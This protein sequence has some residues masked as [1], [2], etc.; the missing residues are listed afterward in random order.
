MSRSF[1]LYLFG[2]LALTLAACQTAPEAPP[3]P[4]SPLIVQPEK[5]DQVEPAPAPIISAV[6]PSGY[7]ALPNMPS[8]ETLQGL[9]AQFHDHV[10]KVSLD[11]LSEKDLKFLHYMVL[12][13]DVVDEIYWMQLS[14]DGLEWRKYYDE[15]DGPLNE[16]DAN[17]HRLLTIYYSTSNFLKDFAPFIG[18]VEGPRGA[19]YYPGDATKEAVTAV[20][21]A[22]KD[23]VVKAQFEDVY[24]ILRYDPNGE[25]EPIP[26]SVAYKAKLAEAAAHLREAAK[27]AD[28]S[29]L[30]KFL[31][32]RAEAFET[33]KYQESD[34]DWVRIEGSRFDVTIGPYE[35]YKDRLLGMKGAFEA[36][37]CINDLALSAEL[38]KIKAYLNKMDTAIPLDQKYR[39]YTRSSGSPIF[40]VDVV[41]ATG[42][43]NSGIK[44]SAFNL[45]NDEDVREK[46]GSKKVLLRPHMEGK[47]K[48]SLYPI[49]Q[50]I[51]TPE[52]RGFVDWVSYFSHALLHE[53]MHGIGPGK[54]MLAGKETTVGKALKELY[55]P[56]EEL[57]ADTLGFWAVNFLISEGFYAPERQKTAAV[58]S[59]AGLF[60]GV[61]FGI[62][63]AHGKSAI[64]MYNYLTELGAFVFNPETGHYSVVFEKYQPALIELAR[65]ILVIEATGDYEAAKAFMEKYGHMPNYM[66]DTLVKLQD[67]PVDIRTI[68]E[69]ADTLRKM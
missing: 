54:I 45:P 20:I 7:Q 28:S 26:F 57:K 67:I 62:E 33:N 38:S 43:T 27:Y 31:L 65:E 1:H 30:I 46:V 3:I 2:L 19:N 66:K 41:L 12:A 11:G 13:A 8:L 35:V 4:V 14:P 22:Q 34:A 60:R 5:L 18:N 44:T 39:G 24:T 49:S 68:Y 52:L 25:L 17:F 63:E 16:W 37:I 36:F 47:F 53:L 55:P 10:V 42:D 15:W 9:N 56:I 21:E 40:A 48:Y 51:L 29:S 50:I 64:M 58:T 23:P 69:T 6:L 61:R 32:S 59:L